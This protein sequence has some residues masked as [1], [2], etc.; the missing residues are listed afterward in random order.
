MHQPWRHCC[1]CQLMGSCNRPSSTFCPTP[2]AYIPLHEY[3]V[4]GGVQA[5]MCACI[6]ICAYVCVCA[7][8]RVCAYMRMC[9]W[10][11]V[12]V[13]QIHSTDH[14][15]S[16]FHIPWAALFLDKT[17]W[18]YMLFTIN[19]NNTWHL[20]PINKQL[21]LLVLRVPTSNCMCNYEP[22]NQSMCN[23]EPYHQSMCN[24]EPYHQSMSTQATACVTMNQTINQC[25]TMNHTINQCVTMNH[26]INQC[27]TMNHTIN[28]CPHKQLH[29]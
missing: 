18:S 14:T 6:Y 29:V 27:V 21:S 25:V 22:N 2:L 9:V 7:C 24:Y 17:G 11:S 23:Y 8:A 3:S 26:T 28:Q 5:C 20:C 16:L 19:N 10:A 15:D 13:V 4:C 1:V 12:W